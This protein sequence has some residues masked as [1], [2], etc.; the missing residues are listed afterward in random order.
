MHGALLV[1]A[2]QQM[3]LAVLI[4]SSLYLWMTM[5]K[6]ITYQSFRGASSL[7]L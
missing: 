6:A 2:T 4:F 7:I 5:Y 1:R 3:E